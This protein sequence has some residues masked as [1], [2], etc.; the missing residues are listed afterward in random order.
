MT[1]GVGIECGIALGALIGAV[2]AVLGITVV[3][4]VLGSLLAGGGA[5]AS[6]GG[7]ILLGAGTTPTIL[8]ST[9][10]VT[11]RVVTNMVLSVVDVTTP[12][13]G[14]RRDITTI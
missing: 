6:T 11:T 10:H 3:G 13:M 4:I 7:G 14:A 12:S 9:I 5:G 1:L 8:L 2:G